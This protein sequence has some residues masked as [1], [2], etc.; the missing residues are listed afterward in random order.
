MLQSSMFQHIVD[1]T[2]ILRNISQPSTSYWISLLIFH[3]LLDIHIITYIYFISFHCQ[4]IRPSQVQS[5]G[6]T[7][8]A[9][10]LCDQDVGT[11]C[12]VQ[13]LGI[14]SHRLRRVQQG[15]PDLRFGKREYRSKASTYTVDSFLSVAYHNIAET[16]PDRLLKP[17]SKVLWANSS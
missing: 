7:A 2:K 13:L 9:C 12:L 3:I 17:I 8:V 6:S 4:P 10:Q 16:L 14:G 11:K 5:S 1:Q 15:A